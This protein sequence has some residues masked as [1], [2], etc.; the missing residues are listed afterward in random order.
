[1]GLDIQRTPDGGTAFICSR[2][3][4]MT[5]EERLQRWVAEEAPRQGR[6]ALCLSPVAENCGGADAACTRPIASL[7]FAVAVLRGMVAG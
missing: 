3:S 1:M 7:A 2:G 4:T 5:P 6:C